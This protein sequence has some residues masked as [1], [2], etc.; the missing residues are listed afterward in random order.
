MDKNLEYRASTQTLIG[1]KQRTLTDNETGEV[2]T[3]DQITKRS[4]G[5]KAFWKCY[6]MD[7]MSVLG[8][9]DSRQV[10]VFIYICENTNPSNNLFIATYKKIAEET[11]CSSA[12]IARI[13]KKL[14]ENNFLRVAQ[15]GVYVVNPNLLM[16]GDDNKRQILLSYYECDEPINQIT[17]SR[18]KRKKIT[19]KSAS[20]EDPEQI[21]ST[22]KNLPVK[23]ELDSLGN[24]S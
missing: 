22:T 7:F 13:M 21:E 9:V 20:A 11:G 5:I 6:L 23:K 12:T 19:N 4:Y 24:N 8:I 3:V 10:D 14:Q 17:Y 18:T 2:I 16:K 1:S 15:R